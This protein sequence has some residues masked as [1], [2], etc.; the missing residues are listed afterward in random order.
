VLHASR[1]QAPND[2]ST[3]AMS[4]LERYRRAGASQLNHTIQRMGASRS[5]QSKVG[6]RWRLA[7]TADG[8]RSDSSHG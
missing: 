4:T 8:G 7:P 5:G 6:S 2:E 1:R 3:G